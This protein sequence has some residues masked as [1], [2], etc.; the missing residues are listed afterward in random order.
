M[1][2]PVIT[3]LVATQTPASL[4]QAEAALLAYQQPAFAVAGADICE[5]LT[6]VLVAQVLM[7]Y[8]QE[9]G[10]TLPVAVRAF[11]RR[12]RTCLSTA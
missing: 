2:L 9:H 11:A 4:H 8:M 12:V 10:A 6:H 1:Q 7:A 5:Q 3:H